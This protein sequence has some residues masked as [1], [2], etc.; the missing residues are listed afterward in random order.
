MTTPLQET[1]PDEQRAPKKKMAAM[2]P[3]AI[4]A[5]LACGTAGGVVGANLASALGRATPTSSK[6]VCNAR[7]VAQAVL[8]TI[9]TIGLVADDGSSSSGSGVIL[10]SDGYI[11]TNNHV[12]APA[13]E[14]AQLTVLYSDGSQ[15][16]AALVGR[17]PRADVAVIKVDDDGLNAI[18]TGDSTALEVGE[19]VVALGAPLG[20]SSTVTTGIV[21]ALGRT[22]PVDSDTN[23]NAVLAEAIQTDASINPGN[24]GGA[25]VDCDGRLVGINSAIATVPGSNGSVGIGFAIPVSVALPIADQIMKSGKVT[26]PT[27][28]AVVTAIRPEKGAPDRHG[29]YVHAVLPGGPSD[30]AGLQEGDIVTS[31]DGT[32]LTSI[33]DLTVVQLTHEPG[34][35]VDVTYE[36]AGEEHTTTVVLGEG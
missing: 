4:V 32:T 29:L 12:V 31:I 19:P 18:N 8:P 21:S 9:V 17:S 6:A 27:I 10:T 3:V 36:R 34:E 13:A 33:D 24:S 22:V 28:G 16:E 15:R 35:S 7:D 1:A 23:R 2:I 20:L 30:Q 5:M 14:G 26:Y 11:L 25:L